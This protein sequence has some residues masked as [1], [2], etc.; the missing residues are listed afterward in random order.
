ME[1]LVF[2]H[3]NSFKVFRVFYFMQ[4][5]ECL[6]DIE[7]RNTDGKGMG[8]YATRDF[9]PGEMVLMFRGSYVKNR[10]EHTVQVE[11][12]LHIDPRE[13]WKY[14]N[15]SCDP[16]CGI[17]NRMDLEAMRPIR[18]GEEVTFDY[19]MTEAKIANLFDCSCGAA[20]C[21]GRVGGFD[22]LSEELKKKYVGHISDHLLKGD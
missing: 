5:D 22:T 1:S 13:P 3:I 14:V 20:I 4:L 21:R 18:K 16:N 12:D 7:A 2:N 9:R 11:K 17:V 8:V 10:S 19:A 6:D 15:H